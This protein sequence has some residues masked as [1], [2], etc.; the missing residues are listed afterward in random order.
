MSEE[1]IMLKLEMFMY[2][3]YFCQS[4]CIEHIC[5]IAINIY[6]FQSLHAYNSILKYDFRF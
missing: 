2:L 6:F 3:V 1:Q 5:L 4:N